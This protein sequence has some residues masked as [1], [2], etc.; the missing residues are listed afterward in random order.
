MSILLW[1]NHRKHV[2]LLGQLKIAR[3]ANE[4]FA[5]GGAAQLKHIDALALAGKTSAVPVV[6]MIDPKEQLRHDLLNMRQKIEW[7]PANLEYQL[8]NQYVEAVKAFVPLSPE[9]EQKLRDLL[10]ERAEAVN[11]AEEIAEAAHD[12]PDVV[13]SAMI[14]ASA[15]LNAKIESTF[16]AD[17]L[18]QIM[19]LQDII[20]EMGLVSATYQ[21]AMA[22]SG[23]PLSTIQSIAL[24]A[25]MRTVY[26]KPES[27]ATM[28]L[29][30]S[31]AYGTQD[32]DSATGLSAPDRNALQRAANLLS[33]AQLQILQDNLAAAT[34][35]TLAREIHTKLTGRK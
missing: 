10:Y 35:R 22:F 20:P 32:I 34:S 27:A 5:E 2:G 28:N 23:Q 16:G 7:D 14:Q 18:A 17:V 31:R 1:Q 13:R 6:T 26:D 11:D 15:E 12:N 29:A 21:P 24:A 30:T 25:I 9:K 4:A 19:K 3:E 33:A 8:V